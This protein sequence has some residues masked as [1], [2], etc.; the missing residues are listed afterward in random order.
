MIIT[1]DGPAGSGKSTAAR[2]LAGELGIAYL[3]SG[4]TYR[5]VALKA[6]REGVD[7]ADSAALAAVARRADVRLVPCGGGVQVL[8]DGRDVSD[9]VRSQEVSDK[10]SQL[11]RWEEV[12]AVLVELQKKIGRELGDF[13]AEGRDQGT[14]VF[15]Q[16]TVK[17]YLDAEAEVRARRRW[18]ELAAAGKESALEDVL[19]AVVER[20][21]RD[22]TRAAGP[23]V[24]APGAVVVDTSH[25]SVEEMVAVM[26]AFVEARR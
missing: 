2:A 16:A 9:L 24:K 17:F 22:S 25:L 7:L 12:R 11:A 5:A 1:I 19:R 3:D 10:A 26:K 4:A 20:D 6:I 13:V 14:V 15:P 18:K 23:L 21:T 8:L